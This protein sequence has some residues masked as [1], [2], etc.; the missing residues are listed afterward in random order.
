MPATH[1]PGSD[2]GIEDRLR[3]AARH[4]RLTVG[5]KLAGGTRSSVHAATDD[6][7]RD[8]VLKLPAA[9]TDARAVTSAEAAALRAW[10]H[11]GAAVMLID[12][13]SDAL[14]LAR[15]RPG[16]P[17]PWQPELPVGE[18]VGVAADLL[19]RLWSSEPGPHRFPGI[20]EVYREDE[21]VAR[22][23][24]AYERRVRGE[25]ERG[26][27]GLTRLPAAS[28]AAARLIST[29]T[30]P[31]LLHGD[32]ITKNLVRDDASPLG[33]VTLDPLPMI[34]DPASEVAAFAAYQPVELILPIAESLA[35]AVGVDANRARGWAAIWAVHQSAQAWRNDQ[36]QLDR[37]VGSSTIG[38][39]LRI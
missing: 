29:M 12:A 20:A 31:R 9:R 24:A 32:F 4:W 19:S 15:A 38:E 23:D 26:S 34:G 33:W 14:L 10:Q 25:P 17:A 28:A 22:E 3:R 27:A 16:M 7:G 8:L 39:L 11:T 35:V 37:L 18:L 21:R 5:E 2:L 36:D 6:L 13:T 30:T 1:A